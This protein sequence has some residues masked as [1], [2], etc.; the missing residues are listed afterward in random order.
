MQ[1]MRSRGHPWTRDDIAAG[2]GEWA[3]LISD[4]ERELKYYMTSDYGDDPDADYWA[5]AD[6]IDL[7]SSLDNF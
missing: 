2:L 3:S 4:V 6:A 7:C 5:M 1:G